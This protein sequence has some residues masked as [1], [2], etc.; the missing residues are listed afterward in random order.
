MYLTLKINNVNFTGSKISSL[1]GLRS[2]SFN[3]KQD[4]NNVNITTTGFGHGVG[5]SQYGAQGMAI[6]GY[7]YN[8]ILKHY[9]SGVKIKKYKF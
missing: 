9:Y 6:E 5:M 8:E 4:K 2:T 3:I 7:K 1:F